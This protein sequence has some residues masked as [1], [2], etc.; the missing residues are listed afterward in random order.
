MNKDSNNSVHGIWGSRWIFILA[1]TGS[2]VGL[3]N[4]WKFPY[5]AGENGGGAFVLFYL[6]C[7]ALIGVPVMMA[8]ILIGRRGRMS[9]INSMAKL[10]KEAQVSRR[11]GYLGVIGA[12]AG[13]LI[14]SFYSVVAGWAL[15]YVYKMASGAFV[16]AT[17]ET[18]GGIWQA[19]TS[20]PLTLLGW[21]TLFTALV[22]VVVAR[23]VN[24][25]LELAVRIL[26]PLLF[27]LL[28]LL[29]GYALTSGAFAEGAAFLFNFDASKLTTDAALVA[30]GHAF[31]TLSLGMGAIMAYGAYMPHKVSIGSTTMVIAGLDTLVALAAGLA[32][33]PVVFANG[34]EPAAGP[35]LMFQTL[36]I[37]FGGMHAGVLFGTLFFVLVVFAAWSSAISLL[38]PAVAWA[39]EK[40]FKRWVATLVVGIAAWTLGI[41]S[42][43]SLNDWSGFK[44]IVNTPNDWGLFVDS[45]TWQA[46]ATACASAT[47]QTWFDF[48]DYLTSS[49]MLPLGGLFIA[50][51]VGWIM[52]ETH[53]RKELAMGNFKLY[54]VWRAVVRIFSPLAI[55]LVFAYST[56]L[57]TPGDTVEVQ[58]GAEC[59]LATYEALSASKESEPALVVPENDAPA[60]D[61]PME[62]SPAQESDVPVLEEQQ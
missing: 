42:V 46:L 28:V 54:L 41:L 26:M 34:L 29:V 61:V 39:V 52:K 31:F 62:E 19:L 25:G 8:E 20:D 43:L 16:G 40:G 15:Y 59:E 22:V 10:A 57:W 38:E 23:G 37:A 49:I 60:T 47:G 48:F 30:L 45:A 35:G 1:A 12:L 17:G 2:A 14:M 32:I 6:G 11:W 51:F 18:A 5:I 21:H 24:R 13:F 56:G 36:P 55:L 58:A 3:G 27:L 7:I 33:F 9:P 53:V 50:I 4:I 44:V